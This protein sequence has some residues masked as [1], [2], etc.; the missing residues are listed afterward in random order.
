MRKRSPNQK[1]SSDHLATAL[2]AVIHLHESL[3]KLSKSQQ[4]IVG[5]NRNERCSLGM[6]TAYKNNLSQHEQSQLFSGGKSGAG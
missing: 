1:Y 4:K 5:T 2:S 3:L 6:F